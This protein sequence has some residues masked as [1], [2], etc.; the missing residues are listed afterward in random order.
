V[1]RDADLVFAEGEAGRNQANG[2]HELAAPAWMKAAQV[3]HLLA[4][5]T[6]D[7]NE[8][9][10]L[11]ERV[12]RYWRRAGDCCDRVANDIGRHPDRAP[13]GERSSLN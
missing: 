6:K 1:K 9:R 11:L 7:G 10:D 12:E 4:E 5:R 8:R 13:P 2:H 3:A